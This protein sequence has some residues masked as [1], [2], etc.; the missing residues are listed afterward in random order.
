[1]SSI[2]SL[3]S[4]LSGIHASQAGLKVTGHNI[5]NVNTAGYTRQ[6]L[7]QHDS[8]YS[9]VKGGQLGT[10]VGLTEIRQIRDNFADTR[11]RKE[12]SVLSFYSVK[13]IAG[14]EIEAI[15]G[16]PH[17]ESI[18]KLLDGFWK[19]TN[20]LGTN[21]SGVEERLSFIQTA[22]TLIKK[23]NHIMD[24]FTNYQYNLN[25]EIKKSVT[26]IN[27][28]L[29]EINNIN[30]E[31]VLDEIGGD[32]A[33]DLRDKRNLL[34]DTLSNYV[35][36]DYYEEKNGSVVVRIE[37]REV[38]DKGFVTELKIEQ[39][40]PGSAFVKPVW[41]DTGNDLFKFNTQVHGNF[42]NDSGSLKSMLITRGIDVADANT[43][44]SDVSINDNFSV[45]ELGN[46]Y[47]IPKLQKE[48]SEFI[49]EMTKEV[50]RCL[51]GLGM[52]D[53]EDLVGVP[54][55][56]PKRS[57]DGTPLPVYPVRDDFISD[58]DYN[59]AIGVYRTDIEKHLVA[60]NIEVNPEL[61]A[62]G[63]YNKLGTITTKGDYSDNS[64][65]S[66][67]LTEW[68]STR[69][70][71]ITNDK[72]SPHSKL[73]SFTDFYAEYVT[74]I[75]REGF[76][77]QGKVKEKVTIVTNIDNERMAMGGVSQDEELS[78]MMKYQYAYNACVRMVN[79]LDGMMDQVINKL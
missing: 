52:G 64:K 44:W 59:T 37:G 61:L 5:S 58:T 49:R 70:W 35:D 40:V 12:S 69:E 21:P 32:N 28:I 19:Q 30:S 54:V 39:T 27:S 53:S 51:D 50:N 73:T 72:N 74:E 18:S 60:G 17:G 2:A 42:D 57:A 62:D 31:L 71:P 1:M 63:G 26:G 3:G 33:N 6:Q 45:S 78:N 11:Y 15:L 68:S 36:I 14:Q 38:V 9:R 23:A 16:E 75:G 10:G 65:I 20:K 67:L 66:N 46:S 79:V 47:M 24:S 41:A 25:D 13:N 48:F 77:I 4:M 8:G 22:S 29:H 34:L 7:I 56:V 76:E 43:Q 55:F